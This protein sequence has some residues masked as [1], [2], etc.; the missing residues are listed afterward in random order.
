MLP[1]AEA[2]YT[3]VN[4]GETG[5]LWGGYAVFGVLLLPYLRWRRVP[6]A[7][8]LDAVALAMPV[9]LALAK[10]ACLNA[11]CCYGARTTLPWAIVVGA[12]RRAHGIHP[13]QLYDAGLLV[14]EALVVA[15]LFWCRALR[16]RLVLVCV[17]MIGL[18][19][20]ATEFT[21]GDL[22][23]AFGLLSIAQWAALMGSSAAVAL[24]LVPA[25]RR[26]WEQY[27]FLGRDD[28]PDG[29]PLVEEPAG[30]REGS[31]VAE[32][33]GR[34][35]LPSLRTSSL[36]QA[37]GALLL[38]ILPVY[39]DVVLV[40]RAIRW[41]CASGLRSE[42]RRASGLASVFPWLVFGAV[43]RF[44]MAA[45]TVSDVA[46]SRLKDIGKG[47]SALTGQSMTEV[48]VWGLMTTMSYSCMVSAVLLGLLAIGVALRIPRSQRGPWICA[49]V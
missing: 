46:T 26:Q 20:M 9:A 33:G 27:V 34:V 7:A 22:R 29:A 11:G 37:T 23:P 45:Q 47:I 25:L 38:A 2:L 12:G 10:L 6:R 44:W 21:R 30:M 48:D 19:R 13:T 43:L 1:G 49:R 17:A 8:I 5:G 16:G 18:G 15:A 32:S 40:A 41:L 36:V 42:R 14:L 39:S 28:A 4:R 24:L 31:P 3:L 35:D